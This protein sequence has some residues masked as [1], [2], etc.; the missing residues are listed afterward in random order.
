MADGRP[1]SSLIR[2][3]LG[4]TAEQRS[5][6]NKETEH[7]LF[8]NNRTSTSSVWA[9]VPFV[10]EISGDFRRMPEI[11][12]I[13]ERFALQTMH[14]TYLSISP[15]ASG[16]VTAD[17]NECRAWEMFDCMWIPVNEAAAAS[18][19]QH[20]TVS[21]KLVSCTA[22]SLHCRFCDPAAAH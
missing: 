8:L 13:P 14:G 5:G 3:L 9:D 20:G 4:L 7:C 19:G 6:W 21:F 10:Q 18:P 22:A 15:S 16:G 2:P 17:K 12:S 11:S 1:G